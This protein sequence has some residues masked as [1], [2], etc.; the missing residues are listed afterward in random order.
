MKYHHKD[1]DLSG[2]SIIRR[3]DNTSVPVKYCN[4][5]NIELCGAINCFWEYGKHYGTNTKELN[6]RSMRLR[7]SERLEFSI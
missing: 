2:V 5:H 6:P 3:P 4:D 1:C 7:I